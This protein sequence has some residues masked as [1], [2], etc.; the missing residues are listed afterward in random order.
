V[1]QGL[2]VTTCHTRAPS[3]LC[4]GTMGSCPSGWT[5]ESVSTSP[6]NQPTNLDIAVEDLVMVA[7]CK[8]AQHCSH[9]TSHLQ[10]HVQ[11]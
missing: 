10:I 2:S 11:G 9:V 4:L 1:A 6:T 5:P 8:R 7:L 3:F